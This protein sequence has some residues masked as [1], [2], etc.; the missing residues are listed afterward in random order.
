MILP[1]W[2][3]R[4]IWVV[5]YCVLITNIYLLRLLSVL[6]TYIYILFG[7]YGCDCKAAKRKN[8]TTRIQCERVA[9]TAKTRCALHYMNNLF[10]FSSGYL[11]RRNLVSQ[12][13]G[14]D[15]D[16]ASGIFLLLLFSL[17]SLLLFICSHKNVKLCALMHLRFTHWKKKKKKQQTPSRHI[18]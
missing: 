17:H 12:V 6:C 18:H 5:L 4:L 1:Q 11:E 8:E 7:F 2:K 16:R 9:S 10:T 15:V 13:V 14:S 3:T